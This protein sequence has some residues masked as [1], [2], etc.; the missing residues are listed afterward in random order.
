[1]KLIV[2]AK[3]VFCVREISRGLGGSV[4]GL[5]ARNLES[6]KSNLVSLNQRNNELGRFST[7]TTK[8]ALCFRGWSV[9]NYDARMKCPILAS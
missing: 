6:L 8:N 1:M 2:G 5:E 3:K 9:I 4:A 7:Q